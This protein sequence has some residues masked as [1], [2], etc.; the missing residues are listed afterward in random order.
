MTH[1]HGSGRIMQRLGACLSSNPNFAILELHD[2]GQLAEMI[3][4]KHSGQTL[5]HCKCSLNGTYYC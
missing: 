1:I 3:H 2:F 5:A 4:A